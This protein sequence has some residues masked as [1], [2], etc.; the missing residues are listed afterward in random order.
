[1]VSPSHKKRAV[2]HV[3]GQDLCS[4]RRACSVVD[5]ASSSYYHRSKSPTDRQQR[6]EQR[7]IALSKKYPRWGYRFIHQLLCRQGW[8]VNRKRVQR[9]RRQEGL[10]V[11]L[12]TKRKRRLSPST[13]YP[14]QADHPG[15]VWS[16][17]FIMDRTTDGRPVKMLT[18]VDEHT[19]QCLVIHPARSLRSDHVLDIL[20][21]LADQWGAPAYIRSDNG[22]EFI[23]HII[24]DWCHL[25]DVQ[26]LYIDPGSPWQNG[27]IESFHSRFRDECLNPEI[28][29]SVAETQVVVEDFRRQYNGQRPHS[30][31]GY[32]TPDEFARRL[33]DKPAE[34]GL[35]PK[36][37]TTWSANKWGLSWG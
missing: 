15:H 17:D 23:A 14:V 32:K 25:A 18:M 4:T 37:W 28:F 16:W 11:R 9:V 30:S 6:L 22:S 26:T 13:G 12:M 34:I 10:G 27:F 36:S 31:L 19:R 21:R 24:R 1:M 35:L 8:R 29:F 20:Q 5:L 7:I 33:K 2:Q 3:A